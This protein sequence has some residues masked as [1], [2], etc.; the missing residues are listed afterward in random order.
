VDKEA[1]NPDVLD[2]ALRPVHQFQMSVL[3]KQG[4]DR[5]KIRGA[6]SSSS[7]RESPSRVFGIST[8]GRPTTKKDQ[9][10]NANNPQL[11]ADRLGGHSLVMDD[12][13]D[14]TGADPE[15]TDQLIRLRT[16][17]GHQILMN[18]TE[19]V[20]YIA[21]ASGNQWVELSANGSIN[22][23]AAAGFNLR[24]KGPI[25]FHSDSAIIM[26]SPKIQ[27]N[28]SG[29]KTP[30]GASIAMTSTGSISASSLMTLSLKTDGKLSASGLALASFSSSGMTSISG[31]AK[32]SVS[33]AGSASI[34]GS[35][36]TVAGGVVNINGGVPAG[37]LGAAAGVLGVVKPAPT[38]NL[39]DTAYNSD[40]RVWV[41]NPEVLSSVCTVVPAHEPWV[42][43][44]G[45]S[46]PDP[47]IPKSEGLLGF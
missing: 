35:A 29:G 36:T 7:I 15:G 3:T 28:A 34:T 23:Y 14:G 21:S 25:N 18:D 32:C 39:Q 12:G 8:P 11:V 13:A 30:I 1:F 40:A 45:K 22:V 16:S 44:D 31:G 9:F 10:P 41:S 5:D 19:N 37:V 6:I 43:D 20:M 2:A 33:S 17:F 26:Q 27:M 38:N 24:S 4:L 42:G 47:Q 46:R